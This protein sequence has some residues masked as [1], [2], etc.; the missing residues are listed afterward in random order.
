MGLNVEELRRSFDLIAPRAE[1]LSQKFYDKLF[2]DYPG[3]LP[4]FQHVELEEQRTKLIAS[5]QMIIK[6]LDND[7]LV[8]YLEAMG[9][10]HEEYGAEEEHYGA[11]GAT[12]L[13]VMGELL[14]DEWTEELEGIWNEALTTVSE[15]MISACRKT[16][17][18]SSTNEKVENL[19]GR[20]ESVSEITSPVEDSQSE[21][22]ENEKMTIE[23][24]TNSGPAGA[25]GESGIDY[26]QLIENSPYTQYVI[27]KDG[28]ISYLNKKGHDVLRSHQAELGFGPEGFVG[29]GASILAGAIPHVTSIISGGEIDATIG[30]SWFKISATP[31][32]D[33]GALH[34][35]VDISDTKAGKDE[36][37]ILKNLANN[38]PI[39][40]IVANKD[41]EII[42]QNPESYKT[43][44][45]LQHLLPVSADKVVGSSIDVFHKVPEKQ[46][47]LLSD[48]KNLPHNAV[49]QLGD[50]YLDLLVTAN[51]S[52][53]GEYL[54]PMVT[55][56]VVT[57]KIKMQE[58]QELLK[59]MV[60]NMPIN[61]VVANKDLVITYQNPES[62]KTLESLQHLL[63][64][65]VDQVVGSSI[66]V[67]HKNP[68]HQRKMLADPNNL[69]HKARIQLGEDFLDLLVNPMMSSKGEY[70]GPMVTWAV[71]SNKVKVAQ[72]FEKDIKG[73]VQIVTSASTELQASSKTLADTSETTAR[74]SQVVA[75]ASEEA[76]KNVETVSSAAE[77]LT[78]S[79]S[80]IARRV[81]EQSDMTSQA[82]DE[83]QKT[84]VTIE[85]LQVSSEEIGQVI[86]VIT[87]IAQQTNLLA[88]NATIEA[89]RAGEAGKG[90]A[91]VAN[92]VKE[93]ARQT[94]KA[95]EEISQKISAIQSATGGA[96]EALQSIRERIGKINEIS[97]TIA[98]AVE[99]Q[100][101]ATNEI[102]RNVS[103]AARGTLEVTE[104]ITSVS[105]AADEAG[106]G[107]GDILAA[108]N[109]LSEE[110]NRL[111]LLADEF[112]KKL[113]DM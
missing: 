67:F 92:E 34:T 94:A 13:S 27:G 85:E 95:T 14:E 93:L 53:S 64:I 100:T 56:S 62:Y 16:A 60:D 3:V 2:Q 65:P 78:A 26:Y 25:V 50:D 113:K 29:Q 91:V 8:P 63:P 19:A 45:S 101:A 102:S 49:I 57:E 106:K 9:Q 98:S 4:L 41:F 73:V 22:M 5:L 89:A 48:P 105:R 36:Y 96:N 79:I 28:K 31:L 66:D 111:D 17:A 97:T 21:F 112:L 6:S 10:R 107:A 44:S 43:L 86:K 30:K 61:A 12:L 7:D 40:A 54:G 55:W 75:A 109:G 11:V 80:E 82:V 20:Q 46:R 108:A 84:N 69:P 83:A 35:W 1:E 90:F 32:S 104:N 39:N 15:I 33:G 38:M 70:L 88:L 68:E 87:S 81:M 77:E 52:D 18:V 59:N 110:S 23:S 51:M 74:Q 72:D 24:V 103:E 42:Y 71:A 47:A 37:E 99:E 58:E 76:T